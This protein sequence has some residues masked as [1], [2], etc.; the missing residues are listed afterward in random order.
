MAKQTLIIS[1]LSNG[2]KSVVIISAGIV[3]WSGNFKNNSTLQKFIENKKVELSDYGYKLE[4][5]S[6]KQYW[7][8]IKEGKRTF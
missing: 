2:E 1:N 5:I 4:V 6:A 3:V 7:K 8:E